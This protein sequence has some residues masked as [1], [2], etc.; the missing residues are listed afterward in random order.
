MREREAEKK[1]MNTAAYGVAALSTG[2]W[3]GGIIAAFFFFQAERAEL[4]VL[5]YSALLVFPLC[6]WAL[7]FEKTKIAGGLILLALSAVSFSVAMSL[8]AGGEFSFVPPGN[9]ELTT[10]YLNILLCFFTSLFFFAVSGRFSF[11]ITLSSFLFFPFTLLS[12]LSRN[13]LGRPLF[14]GGL[15]ELLRRLGAGGADVMNAEQIFAI[16]LA[17][18][19]GLGS[20]ALLF[21]GKILRDK[22]AGTG[23]KAS[24]TQSLIK[25]GFRVVCL[26]FSIVCI[27]RACGEKLSEEGVKRLKK[28]NF[29]YDSYLLR[30]Q[31]L[32]H[33]IKTISVFEGAPENYDKF[34]VRAY[35]RTHEPEGKLRSFATE[36]KKN[37]WFNEW[38]KEWERKNNAGKPGPTKERPNII[39]V[40][41]EGYS[42]PKDIYDFETDVPYAPF[43]DWLRENS[44]TGRVWGSAQSGGNQNTEFEFLTGFS[45]LFMPEGSLIHDRGLN[46]GTPSLVS[47]LNELGYYTLYH[48]FREDSA[49]NSKKL[50]NYEFSARISD[51]VPQ[52]QKFR[53]V[54]SDFFNMVIIRYQIPM[55]RKN[56]EKP[57]FLFNQ[58][59]QNFEPFL[60]RSPNHKINIK[61][62]EGKYSKTEN[63]LSWLRESN[64][65]MKYIEY[66]LR[67]LI[68]EPTVV[69]FF[70]SHRPQLEE[71]FEREKL[72]AEARL[73]KNLHPEYPEKE[74][75]LNEYFIW[76]NFSFTPVKLPDISINYLGEV[77]LSFCG[78]ESS[79]FGKFLER[80]FESWPVIFGEGAFDKDGKFVSRDSVEINENEI[81]KSYRKAQ[82]ALIYGEKEDISE[83]GFVYG[84]EEKRK[85]NQIN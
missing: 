48:N 36:A 55:H 59:A 68:K 1:K 24:K 10:H 39:V 84:Y 38:H 16:S 63:Y 15:N 75:Y 40:M 71:N 5:S 76:A 74:R 78:M 30:Y 18:L 79:D 64:D 56:T 11:A 12:V 45:H 22:R 67:Y 70:G 83:N 42:N 2:L 46:P 66:T 35:N 69:L 34:N 21:F 20:L 65:A 61:V 33:Y 37:T 49:A 25:A 9:H 43:F 47:R 80:S 28:E 62:E 32:A 57:I 73:E 7:S 44:V 23:K 13:V 4:V 31:P 72:S 6:L 54:I 58:T 14:W 85:I 53:G 27:F 19:S 29:Y 82:Y 3:I 77:L 50:E 60:R 17:T 8:A 41:C 81:L 52:K 51:V 26:L